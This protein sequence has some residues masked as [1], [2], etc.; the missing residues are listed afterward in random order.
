MESILYSDVLDRWIEEHKLKILESTTYGYRKALPAIKQYFEG[1]YIIDISADEIYNY[2]Q[3]LKEQY[4]IQTCTRL[5]CKIIRLSFSYAQR[6][7]YILY[8]P[9]VDVVLPRRTRA[10]I[11]PF[12][13]T[14]MNA[15]LQQR[16]IP[17]V[18]D[19]VYIAY[20]TGMR[21]GEIF[22][23]KWSDINFDQ[24][25]IMVQRSQSRA[26]SAVILKSPK[27]RSGIRRIDID[28]G[29]IM[30]LKKMKS[31]CGESQYI[32]STSPR[33][34]YPFR[35]PYNISMYLRDMCLAAGVIPRNFHQIRHTHATVLMAHGVHPK[36]VQ[37]RLGH[38]SI[39]ITLDI[40]SHVAPT[41]QLEA[42]KVFDDL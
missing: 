31:S 16:S 24:K 13:E 33:S 5:Y 19:G 41:L 39:M 30:R 34:K 1:Q 40:Y 36:I 35:V 18:D 15:I 38:S 6:K 23:L 37:E 7:G 2:I 42:V 14:E 32:F 26:C 22:S 3:W 8:N 9:A 17:W 12:S 29:M 25:F 27:T 10:E 4:S 28:S 21:L 20:H 11:F